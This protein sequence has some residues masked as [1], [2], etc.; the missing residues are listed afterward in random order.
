MR[1]AGV[2]RNCAFELAIMADDK[3]SKLSMNSSWHG[4][5]IC[6][7]LKKSMEPDSVS[8]P[9][10]QSMDWRGMEGPTIFPNGWL[11]LPTP[12]ASDSLRSTLACG[13]GPFLA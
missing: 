11:K 3:E 7:S 2:V 12:V 9:R 5:L 4:M 1:H 10:T 6:S 13:S 8:P